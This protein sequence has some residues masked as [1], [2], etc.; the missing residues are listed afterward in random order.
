MKNLNVNITEMELYDLLNN[1][2]DVNKGIIDF[3]DFLNLMA[4]KI[5]KIVF[6]KIN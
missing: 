4:K 5:N 1:L 2:D 6:K 3:P